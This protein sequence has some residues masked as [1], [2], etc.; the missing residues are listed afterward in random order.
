MNDLSTQPASPQDASS[1]RPPD[2]LNVR[3]LRKYWTTALAVLV[4]TVVGT[5]FFT[6]GQKKIYQAEGTVMFDPNPPSPL[7]S[8]VESVVDI[9]SGNFWSN[10]E[11]YET[12]YNII[13]SRRLAL[14]VV[15]ELGLQ[16]DAAFISNLPAGERPEHEAAVE[17]ERAAEVLRGR[18]DVEPVQDSRLAIIKLRDADPERAQR[19]LSTLIDTYV[20]QNLDNA[21]SS[22]SSATDWLRSQLDT[23]KK[24][25]ESSELELH[26]YKKEKDILSVKFDDKSNMLAEEMNQINAELTRVRGLQQEAIARRNVLAGA[27]GTDPRLIQA[28]E[29]LR[30]PLLNTLRAD[31]ESAVRERD[32]LLGE[33]KGAHHPEVAAA[34]NRVKAAEEA[35]L[36]E[37]NNVKRAADREVA[38]LARQAGGLKGMLEESRKQAHE[39][40]LLEIEYN[41]LR[42]SKENTEKL[43][44]LVLSRTKE[45]DLSQMLR[46]NNISIVDKP[47]QPQ[48]AVSPVVP[49][50]M[51]VGVVIGLLLGVASAFG[52]A[53]MDRTLK[54]PDDIESELGMT[55]IGLLPQLEDMDTPPA[56]KPKRRRGKVAPVLRPELAVHDQ[57]TSSIAEAA[58]SIRTNLMFLSPDEPYKTLVITSAGPAE[59]K[60]TVTCC[61]AVAMA[62]AGQ[63]VALIDCDL[64]RPR[65][66][67]IFGL[68]DQEG[69]TTAMLEN[70]FEGAFFETEVP[71]LYVMPS[72][73]IPPNPAEL[74]HT[75]RFKQLLEYAQANFDR[76]II[77]SAPVVAVTDPT[78]LSTIA[79]GTVLVVR[80]HKTRKEL[81]HHAQRSL[82]AVGG[83]LLGVILN[84]VD[85]S[86]S[87]YK[88]SYYYYRR[89][90]YYGSDSTEPRHRGDQRDEGPRLAG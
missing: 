77:D 79:D 21:L 4:V 47:L 76:V 11:Y 60:T 13:K 14:Q 70:K 66:R 71:N 81:A 7:G 40:N 83:N 12:Q 3:N 85:F 41:R 35:I 48:T 87:E 63:R 53:M 82:A 5:T 33:G 58:R 50:N 62:Q 37:I 29:L 78:I 42:R 84:A 49:L 80:A 31:Y 54:V 52:R 39:L 65:I 51:A 88:Y 2:V 75:E 59:G 18:L 43:Y 19:L 20:E 32:A 9:G 8:Q 44:S 36:K 27:P 64:R 72:G 34:N 89:S 6:L 86:R 1:P 61:I 46:V 22:T 10:Q 69:V 90:E 23:L 68:P 38:V 26:Q 67:R 73:P 57:P 74:L 30:S 56:A 15:K 17:P 16:N 45:A 24:D 55:C 28:N 25:L